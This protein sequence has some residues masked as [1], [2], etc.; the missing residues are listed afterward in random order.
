MSH[1]GTDILATV[2]S[3]YREHFEVE[4]ARASVSFLGVD[5]IEILR[6]DD[7]DRQHFASLGMA[8]YPMA[9]PQATIVDPSTA[10]RAELMV[11]VSH[12]ADDLWRQLAVLAAAPAIEGAVYQVGNRVDLGQPLC[13][14][15]RCTGGVLQPSGL[16]AIEVAGLASVQVLELIP[17]TATELA[18]ARVH[19]TDAL[20]RRWR[21][22]KTDTADLNRDAVEL[23]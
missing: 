5:P 15:S 19:G 20:V 8:R 13:A 16:Q 2:E 1:S 23:E 18:W 7:H 21:L 10:P 3:R 12:A 4:P 14:G 9:D 6:F 11:S 22:A 17:A